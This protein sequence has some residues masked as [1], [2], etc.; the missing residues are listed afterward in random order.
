MVKES[1]R[2]LP[3]LEESQR[4]QQAFLSHVSSLLISCASKCASVAPENTMRMVVPHLSSVS[5]FNF[6]SDDMM[7][8]L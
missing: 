8:A 3:G 7:S 6:R 2:H 1:H 5:A 4:C